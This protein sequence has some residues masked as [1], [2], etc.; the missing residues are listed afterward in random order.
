MELIKQYDNKCYEDLANA[1]VIQAANDYRAACK[2]LKKGDHITMYKIKK[3]E[4]F[5]TSEWGDYL[6]GGIAL[7]I[8]KRLQDE[9]KK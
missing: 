3:I 4:D 9:Q 5:F 2:N 7:K 1:I 6:S 8:L